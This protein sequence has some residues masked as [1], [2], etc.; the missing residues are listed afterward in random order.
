M[1]PS[2]RLS[3][4]LLRRKCDPAQ[5]DF[6]TTS[7]LPELDEIVGQARAVEAIRFGVG[8]THDGYNLFVLGRSGAGKRTMLARLLA[9]R[10]KSQASPDGWCYVNDFAHPHKPRALRL[11]PGRATKLRQDMDELVEEL[12]VAVPATFEGETYRAR[13]EQLDAEFSSRQ[14][15]AFAE[16]GEDAALHDVALVRTPVGLTLMPM[17]DGETMSEK[18][19]DALPADKRTAFEEAIASLKERLEKLLH[20]VPVWHKERRERLRAL[21]REMAMSAVGASMNALEKAYDDLPAVAEYLRAVRV[22]VLDNVDAFRKLPDSD[23][24][25]VPDASA[26]VRYRVNVLLDHEA[27]QG[28]PVVY[29]DFPSYQNLVGRV[30]HRAM[31]GTLVTDFSLI[32]PGD[33]HRANGGYLLLEIDKVLRQPFAWEGLKRALLRHEVRIESLAEMFSMVSTVSLEPEPVPLDVKVVLFGERWLY[34]LLYEMDP[35]FGEL[36]KVPADFE[37]DLSR[38]AAN[39][40]RYARL[41]ASLVKHH[42]LLPL[43]RGAVMRVVEQQARSAGDAEKISLHMRSLADLLREAEFQARQRGGKVVTDADVQA[44]VDAQRARTDRVRRRLQEE[45]LRGTVLIDTSGAKSGQVN[46]LWVTQMGG[47]M[48]GQPARITART[49]LGDGEVVDIQREARLGGA[50]HSKAVMTI[51]SFLTARYSS[52]QPPCLSASL[53]F[54][55]TYGEVE[56]DSASVAEV[57]ALIS[58]LADVPIRQTLAVTGSIDQYGSVQAIGGVNEKIEGFFDLCQARGLGGDQGVVIPRAN[59]KHLMLR[60]DVVA[61]AAAGR[62]HIY[63][64]ESVDEAVEVLTGIAAGVADAQGCFPADSVNGR[65]CA[66]LAS[67]AQTRRSFVQPSIRSMTMRHRLRAAS[68]NGHVPHGVKRAKQP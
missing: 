68:S 58:S 25:P 12:K 45:T 57:C 15:K 21:N 56:G 63:A 61:A 40:G 10:A 50:I 62:F 17:R 32:K 55:Q 20:Q 23:G 3:A 37:E 4:D 38:D 29:Q 36:F 47:V 49:R 52:G 8:M 64:V 44:A 46:G 6:E 66:R 27:G 30:E 5:F 42:G 34:Y 24:Q 48:F 28:A 35:D 53:T 11:P 1:T 9:D 43:D 18:D 22:D 7:D 65:V 67:F 39:H 41:V 14:E 2:L 51:A 13:A 26:F 16:L 60:E 31:L 59:I 54:E 33:L 19:Y